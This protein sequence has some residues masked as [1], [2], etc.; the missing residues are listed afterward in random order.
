MQLSF[1][2]LPAEIR[3]EIYG[4]ALQRHRSLQVVR[5]WIK[6]HYALK[7]ERSSLVPALLA[8]CRAINCEATPILY[9]GSMYDHRQRRC[10]LIS[11]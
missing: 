2:E 10:R 1:L 9:G 5:T 8:T 4:Q 6:H 11:S 7:L 3:N